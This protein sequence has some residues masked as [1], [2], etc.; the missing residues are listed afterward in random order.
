MRFE[1]FRAIFWSLRFRLTLWNTTVVLATVLLVLFGVREGLWVGLVHDVDRL[2]RDDANEVGLTLQADYP[3]MNQVYA[4]IDRKVRGHA[5]RDLFVQLFDQNGK[6]IWSSANTPP[7]DELKQAD[8]R[9]VSRS[10]IPGYRLEHKTIE[11]PPYTIRVGSSLRVINE[12]VAK[13]TRLV[14]EAGIVIVFVAPLGGYWL[15]GR[16]TRPLG[17]IITTAARLRPSHMDERLPIRGTYDELDK[18][19][20]TINRF[21]DLIADYL[22]RNRE[23]VANAAHELRSPLAAI[24]SSVDVTLNSQRS[25]AEYQDLLGEISDQCGQLGTLVNQ[26]LLLAETDAGRFQIEKQPVALNRLVERSI[27]MFRGAAEEEGIL[28]SA[29]CSRD[30]RVNGDADRLR[31]VIQNLIDNSLKFTPN[32]GEVRVQVAPDMARRHVTLRVS[33]SGVGIDP[34]DLPHVFERF[35]RGD[36]SRRREKSMHGNGLGLSIC[37]SIVEAHGGRI[38]VESTPGKGTIFC[39]TLPAEGDSTEP[40]DEQP[41]LLS[42]SS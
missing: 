20:L 19:S 4:E 7:L 16:A 41:P 38:I 31:Q 36:K 1:Q 27:E 6:E 35:Y 15:A 22:E 3:N 40:V 28:L 13:L 11:H 8:A 21:L 12:D 34:V 25:V 32:G 33:D 29:E 37:K 39:V 14:V 26:L 9:T 10:Q 5:D 24:Q 42:Y 2:L 18:L 17:R 23:F 30:A